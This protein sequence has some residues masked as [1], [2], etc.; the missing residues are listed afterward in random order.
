MELYRI[1][2]QP[3]RPTPCPNGECSYH[4]TGHFMEE[5]LSWHRQAPQ[6]IAAAS[7]K[8]YLRNRMQASSSDAA[9]LYTVQKSPRTDHP[10][11]RHSS[12]A[13]PFLKNQTPPVMRVGESGKKKAGRI[14]KRTREISATAFK[15]LWLLRRATAA[16]NGVP[17]CVLFSGKTLAAICK[18]MPETTLSKSRMP[19]PRSSKAAARP[20]CL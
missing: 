12:R 19:A 11:R 5:T 1:I 7:E 14:K 8:G 13:M 9:Y 10:G 2:K 17:P 4:Q 3:H 20:F 18:T 16:E 15:E 6:N